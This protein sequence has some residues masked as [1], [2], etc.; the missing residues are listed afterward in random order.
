MNRGNVFHRNDPGFRQ[1]DKFRESIIRTTKHRVDFFKYHI[2]RFGEKPVHFLFRHGFGQLTLNR[3][4]PVFLKMNI[5]DFAMSR[6]HKQR[7]LVAFARFTRQFQD[8]F[9]CEDRDAFPRFRHALAIQTIQILPTIPRI[10]LDKRYLLGAMDAF[11]NK[12]ERNGRRVGRLYLEMNRPNASVYI[13]RG[14]LRIVV[15][16]IKQLNG[17]V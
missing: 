2:Q 3:H 17:L 7:N 9:V 8:L 15:Y 10:E 5:H 16:I 13:R 11:E 14:S 1:R 4:I 12:F 6:S